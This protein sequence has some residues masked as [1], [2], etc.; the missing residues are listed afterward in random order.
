LKWPVGLERK[1]KEAKAFY[2]VLAVAT[3]IGLILNF[4]KVDPIKALVWAVII[5]GITATPVM[6]FTMLLA[7]RRKVMGRA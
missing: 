5:N 3:L 2:S 4:T 6:C 7:S 1:A